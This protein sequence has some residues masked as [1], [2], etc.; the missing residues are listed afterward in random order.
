MWDGRGY[1][2]KVPGMSNVSPQ[3]KGKSSRLKSSMS[4]GT[5]VRSLAHWACLGGSSPPAHAHS[6][7]RNDPCQ[8]L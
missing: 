8:H 7:A 5:S 6:G 4:K 3:K 2:E 1:P